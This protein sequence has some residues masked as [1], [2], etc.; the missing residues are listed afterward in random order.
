MAWV[1]RWLAHRCPTFYGIDAMFDAT[2]VVA[3]AITAVVGLAGIG[4]QARIS[5]RQLDAERDRHIA[6]AAAQRRNERQEAYVSILDLLADFGW[7]S[8]FPPKNYDVVLSFT[9]P[10]LHA[11]NRVRLYGSPAAIAAVYQLQLAFAALNRRDTGTSNL[12]RKGTEAFTLAARDDVGPRP[13]D[14]LKDVDF[15]PGLG[16]PAD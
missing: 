2:V 13:E 4:A 1:R 3:T 15:P 14:G 11:A 7:D 8:E 12:F 16:P 6:D 10:F 9:K 5:R